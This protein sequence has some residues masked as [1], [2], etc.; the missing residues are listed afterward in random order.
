MSNKI[1][2]KKAKKHMD[3]K[4]YFCS[5]DQ[6]ELLDVHRIVEGK[7]GGKYVEYNCV[8]VCVSCHRKIHNGLIKIFRKYYS[9]IGKYVLHYIDENGVEHFD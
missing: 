1:I 5:C 9:T 8:T 4:C 3:G 2:N 6:Y 7:D